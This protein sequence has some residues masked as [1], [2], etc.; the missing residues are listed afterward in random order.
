MLGRRHSLLRVICSQHD[1]TMTSLAEMGEENKRRHEERMKEGERR[2]RELLEENECRHQQSLEEGERRHQQSL[3]ESERRHQEWLEESARRDA[4]WQ[5][6]LARRD[7]EMREF[8]RE[9][10]LRN[11]KVYTS[12]LAEAQEGREQLRANTQ[13]VLSVLDRLDRRDAA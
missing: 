11:E 13:A 7:E 2:H 12:V 5:A 1:E 6:D 10:L 3:E 8:N 9:I 4:E